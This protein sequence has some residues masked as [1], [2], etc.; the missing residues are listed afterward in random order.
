MND[1]YV[2]LPDKTL[3]LRTV[4]NAYAWSS[5]DRCFIKPFWKSEIKFNVLKYVVSLLLSEDEYNFDIRQS[6]LFPYN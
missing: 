6:R 3:L 1:T 4:E 2:D 5:Q